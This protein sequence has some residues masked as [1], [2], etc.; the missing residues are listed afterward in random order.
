[1]SRLGMRP[2]IAAVVA[3][4]A[5]VCS[6]LLF[7]APVQADDDP[8]APLITTWAEDV[9]IFAYPPYPQ[10]HTV[11]PQ[12]VGGKT[13]DPCAGD[14]RFETITK[15]L[16]TVWLHDSMAYDAGEFVN[17][18]W[19]EFFADTTNIYDSNYWKWSIL[20]SAGFGAW[21]SDGSS[22]VHGSTTFQVKRHVQFST[23]NASPEPVRKGSPIKVAG[24]VTR[25]G[26]TSTRVAKYVP[27]TAHPVDV[28]FRAAMPPSTKP[29]VKVART[30][31]TS[32]G[33]FAKSF[34]ATVDGCWK[35]LSTKTPT[36]IGAWSGGSTGGADCVDV[37]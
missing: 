35:A 28:Y 26:F 8:C 19:T 34:T 10:Q 36:H 17:H 21:V 32:T 6:P 25:L 18:Y 2:R 22:W 37:Q 16:G 31:T 15:V 13:E 20:G 7:A 24:V 1:M 33:A 27:Y 5:L 14:G 12:L 9:V 11:R 23:F 3:V 29:Y 4:L 30:T